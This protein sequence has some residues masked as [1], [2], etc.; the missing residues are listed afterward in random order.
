MAERK[1][2]RPIGELF[3]ELMSETRTLLKQEITL[4]RT[5]VTQ[6]LLQVAK[7]LAALG[8][9]GVVLYTGLLTL[10]AALVAGGATFIPVWL[11]ALIVG[12]L[13]EVVGLGLVQKGRKDLAHMEAVP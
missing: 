7:D 8:A 13:L 4:V 1:E 5:E 10:V 3:S 2:D 11:S 12:V 9:G 6:K